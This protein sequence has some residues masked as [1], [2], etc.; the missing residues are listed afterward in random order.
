MRRA[1]RRLVP[2]TA[3]A[4]LLLTIGGC[5]VGTYGPKVDDFAPAHSGRGVMT[6]LL[7]FEAG[8]VGGELLEVREAGLL[9]LTAEPAIVFFPWATIRHA[10][11]EDVPATLSHGDVPDDAT[12]DGLRLVSRHPHGLDE[13]QLRALLD[14]YGLDAVREEGS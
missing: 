7:Q 4:A 12:R 2:A 8:R 5:R 1:T 13:A 9:V 11:F 14:A 3:M 6:R 10:T